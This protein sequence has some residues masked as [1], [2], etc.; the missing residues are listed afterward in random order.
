MAHAEGKGPPAQLLD[1]SPFS[2]HYLT[3]R[4]YLT[5]LSIHWISRI[6]IFM[7]CM[8]IIVCVG[9]TTFGYFGNSEILEMVDKYS[10]AYRNGLLYSVQ[11]NRVMVFALGYRQTREAR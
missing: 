1:H 9:I 5:G 6:H 10:T 2:L 4:A 8:N 11:A 7:Q 3:L